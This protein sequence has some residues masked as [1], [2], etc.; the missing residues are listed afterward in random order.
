MRATASTTVKK[1]VD[2]VW[3]VLADHE[4]MSTWAPGLKASIE[5]PGAPER[6]GLGAVRR[7]AAAG[8][9]PPIVEEITVF[10]PSTRLGYKAL[11][12][13]P[14]KN[15]HGLV[16][17]TPVG[18]HTRIDYS[19]SLDLPVV[20]KVPAAAIAQTLLRLLARAAA[21]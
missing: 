10:E 9:M 8:P 15:Y 19:I 4:G 14:F 20:G 12:G 6:N 17:L 3:S 11:K 5:K 13:V 21:R 7:I 1:S 18:G 16:E 2:H